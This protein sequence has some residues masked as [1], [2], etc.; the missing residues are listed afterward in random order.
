MNITAK[1]SS[2]AQTVLPKEVRRKLGV[3]P[4]DT[5]RFRDTDQG[6]VIE[7]LEPP[8]G[9]DACGDP[10]VAFAEWGTPEEDEAWKDL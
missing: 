8:P 10:F 9:D 2:K 4:G 5:I 7:K 3:S 6:I 1:I